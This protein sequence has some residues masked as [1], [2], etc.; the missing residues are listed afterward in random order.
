[1]GQEENGRD[2]T[3]CKWQQKAVCGA[4]FKP[5]YVTKAFGGVSLLCIVDLH[6]HAAVWDGAF[7]FCMRGKKE[8]ELCQRK[9]HGDGVL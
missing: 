7:G 8:L 9:V 3:V 2:G 5:P 6:L 1:M 4:A